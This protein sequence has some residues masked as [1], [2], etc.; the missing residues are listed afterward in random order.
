MTPY[1]GSLPHWVKALIK[2][3]WIPALIQTYGLHYS[4]CGRLFMA[5]ALI[6]QILVPRWPHS[7]LSILCIFLDLIVCE[8]EREIHLNGLAT[9]QNPLQWSWSLSKNESGLV[10]QQL[11]S[12]LIFFQAGWWKLALLHNHISKPF[13]RSMTCCSCYSC[14]YCNANKCEEVLEETYAFMFCTIFL[15]VLLV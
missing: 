9:L 7:F 13:L 5:H 3:P 6:F 14:S 8:V 11:E 4:F 12:A 15:F 2:C 1:P 10:E